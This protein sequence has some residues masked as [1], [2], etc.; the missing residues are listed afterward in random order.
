ML[1]LVRFQLPPQIYNSS[2]KKTYFECNIGSNPIISTIKLEI[3]RNGIRNS[4]EKE[5]IKVFSFFK[6]SLLS[7]L[8]YISSGFRLTSNNKE[9]VFIVLDYSLNVFL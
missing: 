5:F 1:A 3:W 2:G 4:Y 9:W 8:L 6:C 7:F